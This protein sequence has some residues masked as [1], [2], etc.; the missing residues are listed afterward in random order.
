MQIEFHGLEMLL[1]K[2]DHISK[3]ISISIVLSALIV[4]AAIVSQWEH[5]KWVGTVIFLLSGVFGFW[6]LIKLWRNQKFDREK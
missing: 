2:L 3:R 1:N 4:G 6:L 5:M